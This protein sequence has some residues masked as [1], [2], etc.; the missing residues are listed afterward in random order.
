MTDSPTSAA[1]STTLV[2][3]VGAEPVTGHSDEPAVAVVADMP[4]LPRW[5][6]TMH[7]DVQPT[8]RHGSL[9]PQR[10]VANLGQDSSSRRRQDAALVDHVVEIPA[11]QPIAEHD[12]VRTVRHDS[13]RRPRRRISRRRSTTI[14]SRRS[15]TVPRRPTGQPRQRHREYPR[16]LTPLPAPLTTRRWTTTPPRPGEL[17][18]AHLA[19]HTTHHTRTNTFDQQEVTIKRSSHRTNAQ[20][21][22][23]TTTTTNNPHA[24]NKPPAAKQPQQGPGGTP[25]PPAPLAPQGIGD[26]SLWS[27]KTAVPCRR[28]F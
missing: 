27:E 20:P 18:P 1:A 12:A 14:D 6:S 10:R 2:A 4:A 19:P 5:T 7:E 23:P 21:P 13:V 15:L 24:P 9:D 22:T 28:F 8:A 3:A 17:A 26:L 16:P 11:R 25:S